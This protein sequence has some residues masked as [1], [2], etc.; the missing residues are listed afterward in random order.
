MPIFAWNVPLVS[1]IFLKT[2]LVFPILLFSS[3]SLHW[4]LRKSFLSVLAILWNS[5]FKWVYLSFSPLPL[6]SL[7]FSA[8]YINMIIYIFSYHIWYIIIHN[9]MYNHIYYS[10]CVYIWVNENEAFIIFPNENSKFPEIIYISKNKGVLMLIDIC[11]CNTGSK[12]TLT[13]SKIHQLMK[14][15][16]LL[17]NIKA[18]VAVYLCIH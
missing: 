5:A 14:L 2:S 8:I 10:V 13:S 3:I 11:L 17:I 15:H 7:L 12:W 18:Q 4:S 1:L 6:A 16:G 9:M